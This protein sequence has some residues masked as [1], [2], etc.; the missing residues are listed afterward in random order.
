M[1]K[2]YFVI[3]LRNLQ[4]RKAFTLINM[5]GLVIAFTSCIFITLFVLDELSYDRF[6]K[7]TD[8]IFKVW[9]KVDLF[10]FTPTNS[11]LLAGTLTKEFPEVKAAVRIQPMEDP[12]YFKINNEQVKEDKYMFTD[13]SIFRI[14]SLPLMF[15][16]SKTAL[17][18]PHS[19]VI[20]KRIAEKYF[21]VINPL[22]QILRTN[23]RSKWYDLQVTGVL[24]KMPANS[25]FNTD[26]MFSSLVLHEV[27]NKSGREAAEPHPMERWEQIST[28]TYILLNKGYSIED[29]EV[30]MNGYFQK[31][32]PNSYISKLKLEPLSD[33]H[34]YKID[35]TGVQKPGSVIYVYLFSA[36]GVLILLV[37]GL[38][39]IILSTANT[40][41]RAKEI[42]LRKVIGARRKDLI[43]QFLSESVLLAFIALPISLIAVELLLPSVNTL[44]AKQFGANYFQLWQLIL[45]LSGMTLIVGIFSGGYAA[46]Y[47]SSLSPVTILQNNSSAGNSRGGLRKTLIILQFTIFISLMAGSIVI[48][49]QIKYIRESNPGFKK[50]QLA[51]IDMGKSD[52]GKYFNA[53]KQE[54]IKN[55]GLVNISAG[56][57]IPLTETTM[58]FQSTSLIDNPES[59]IQYMAGYVYYNFFQ[60]LGAHTL[61]GR[62]FSQDFSQDLTESVMLNKTAVRKF[63]LNN[64]VGQLIQLQDGRKKVIGVV[65]DF[66][67]SC[68]YETSPIVYYLKPGNPVIGT[69]ILR[70]SPVN[71]SGTLK[72]L[73][74]IWYKYTPDAV[75]SF[76][77][78]DEEINRQYEK[79]LRFGKII[80]ILTGLSILIASL[81]LFGLSLFMIRRRNKEIGIRKI[82]G[83][84]LHSLVFIQTKEM[85][86][87][88][89]I[90][91]C[92]AWPVAY[93]FM[94][95]WLEN[96]AYRIEISWWMFASAGVLALLI[97]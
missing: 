58:I 37:A 74:N 24:E 39:Y 23:I 42:G 20:S 3:A 38:N 63:G 76:R 43:K 73:E 71:M 78:I 53:F 60:T 49:Q 84:S 83:A 25:D 21:G 82:L 16:D 94:N 61:Q 12:V 51:A 86:F 67:A 46:F 27:L 89:V 50:E 35:E 36:I 64:P 87:L 68:Y 44:L 48:S 26:F 30:K 54:A 72:Y 55:P 8:Q 1:L 7:N 57:T 33:I 91:S 15:G 90:G 32:L 95:K 5:S 13:N 29:L 41:V 28:S 9:Q 11:W 62:L 52:F 70:L 79:D 45:I 19:V 4:K 81:G 85:I 88:V 66:V 96:F 10:G 65:D 59:K 6:H 75:F 97:A 34:L 80:T 22:G 93:Y 47:L 2:S 18:I 77:F 69:M 14:F 17:T 92:I 56:S 40:S 31:K